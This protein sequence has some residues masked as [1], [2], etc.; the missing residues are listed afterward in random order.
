M[1]TESCTFAVNQA[2]A[3]TGNGM[4]KYTS[5]KAGF[6]QGGWGPIASPRVKFFHDGCAYW[7]GTCGYQGCEG[8]RYR[9]RR[10]GV[11]HLT[12]DPGCISERKAAGK[13]Q[14]M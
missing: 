10:Q 11:D 9:C 8:V 6:Y 13:V 7:G 14:N 3:A 12:S 1:K 2:L 4:G 5:T